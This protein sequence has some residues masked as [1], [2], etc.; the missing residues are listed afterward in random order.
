MRLGKSLIVF[1]LIFAV[2][3]LAYAQIVTTSARNQLPQNL[4]QNVLA[5]T[6]VSMTN[7]QFNWSAGYIPTDQIGTFTTGNFQNFPFASG[8]IMTTGNILVAEGP[9]DKTNAS[10][11]V[12]QSTTVRDPDL[13]ALVSKP[14]KSTTVLE[15]DFIASS[16]SFEFEYVFASE[17]YPEYVCSQY[18][19]VFGFFLTG[20]DPVT[21]TITTKNIAVI[22]NSAS[23]VYPDGMPVAIN[24]LN[25]GVSGTSFQDGD[26]ISLDYSNYYN[27]NPVNDP[28]I[29]FDGYTAALPARASVVPCETYHMKISLANV[30]DNTFDSGVFLKASSFNSPEFKIIEQYDLPTCDS[31][32]EGCNDLQLNFQ[33]SSPA[34]S[35]VTIHLALSGTATEGVDF[36]AI[37]HTLYINQGDSVVSINI[38]AINDHIAENDE[39]LTITA[40]LDLCG[41]TFIKSADLVIVDYDPI[42]LVSYDTAA[43]EICNQ[44]VAKS[45]TSIPAGTIFHWNPTDGMNNSTSQAPT[46][47]ITQDATYTV[48]AETSHGCKSNQATINAIIVDKPQAIFTAQP[49]H[50]CAPF[51][52]NFTSQSTPA[53][54]NLEWDFGNGLTSTETNPSVTYTADGNYDVTLIASLPGG[55]CADTNT[56]VNAI[57]PGT[58][59]T[60]DFT[61]TPGTALNNEPVIFTNTS[62]GGNIVQYDWNFGDGFH[63]SIQC[64]EHI[65]HITEDRYYTI[66]LTVTTDEN[67]SASFASPIYVTDN[68]NLYVPNAFTP[69]NDGLNDKF[70]P[71]ISEAEYYLFTIYN[72]FGQMIFQTTDPNE[73]WDGTH[74]GKKC[75][76]GLYTWNLRYSRPADASSIIK[77]AGE[78]TLLR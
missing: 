15:F 55:G 45:N 64:P 73:G 9:N 3:D 35:P 40:T 58:L 27:A 47:S 6:G 50:G 20:L 28:N 51:T 16:S 11:N 22:P 25:P 31:L 69:N 4:I 36:D 43:C 33:L 18:N 75:V 54:A 7:G 2:C 56:V 61:F 46:V 65:Y 19:D 1:L 12:T 44:V 53:I 14:L 17:E 21:Q 78:V 13:Q 5:G 70:K 29:Q 57:T 34:I 23:V 49:N 24:S 38:N 32:V 8:I 39:T 74:R 10:M 71:A 63:D 48:Y 42:I 67:C 77:I 62:T 72:R 60:A 68:F 66:T 30:N 37:P 59:P 76:P 41:I 52:V 26:C